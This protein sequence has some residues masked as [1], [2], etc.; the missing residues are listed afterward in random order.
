MKTECCLDIVILKM[1][2]TVHTIFIW[3]WWRVLF[4]ARQ[5][6]CPRW[7]TGGVA[8]QPVVSSRSFDE[9]KNCDAIFL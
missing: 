5:F 9:P 4:R 2:N 3:I 1:K 8:K 7:W 6:F